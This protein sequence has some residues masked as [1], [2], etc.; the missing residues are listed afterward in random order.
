MPCQGRA[1]Q[2][3]RGIFQ[4]ETPGT[5]GCLVSPGPHQAASHMG[6]EN[7]KFKVDASDFGSR[8][9]LPWKVH[10]VANW[11]KLHRSGGP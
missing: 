1:A 2:V 8:L 11:L 9:L 10:R 4:D 6:T 3:G 7:S 5:P